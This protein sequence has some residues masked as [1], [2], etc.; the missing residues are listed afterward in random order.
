MFGPQIRVGTEA[1]VN[2]HGGQIQPEAAEGV[3]E[4]VGV[5]A[6][7]VG[8]EVAPG[9]GLGLE[10]AAKVVGNVHLN[11][12]TRGKR[13]DTRGRTRYAH[14]YFRQREHNEVLPLYLFSC[15]FPLP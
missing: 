6:A 13:K 4:N 11:P 7:A 10:K 3:Q 2:M 9:R 5:E 8:D 1:V 12:D 14:G 15:I